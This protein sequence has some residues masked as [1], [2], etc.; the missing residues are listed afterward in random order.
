MSENNDRWLLYE[1]LVDANRYP[2]GGLNA[3]QAIF[4]DARVT[5]LSPG[6][7]FEN[8]NGEIATR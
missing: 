8:S 5:G 6:Q 3:I 4:A 2:R 1:G 7:K